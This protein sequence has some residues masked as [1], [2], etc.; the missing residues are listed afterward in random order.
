[1]DA[2]KI[3]IRRVDLS[4]CFFIGEKK[5]AQLWATPLGSEKAVKEALD[6]LQALFEEKGMKRNGE[7]GNGQ[8]PCVAKLAWETL[9]SF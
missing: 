7:I 9:M 5:I 2:S 3:H 4:I 6:T 1:M 8:V